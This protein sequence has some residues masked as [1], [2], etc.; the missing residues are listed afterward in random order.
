M[1]LFKRCSI[2]AADI[3]NHFT[4]WNILQQ[5][6][7]ELSIEYMLCGAR[8]LAAGIVTA[9]SVLDR[10]QVLLNLCCI[11]SRC[12]L[13]C[14]ASNPGVASRQTSWYDPRRSCMTCRASFHHYHIELGFGLLGPECCRDVPLVGVT[15]RKSLSSRQ[16]LISIVE[17]IND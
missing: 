7:C 13:T 12:C 5:L 9:F 8:P 11:E 16:G 17:L 10:I 2:D 3:I 1:C 6:K 15:S 14:A 4:N